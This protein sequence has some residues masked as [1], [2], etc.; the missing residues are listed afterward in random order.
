MQLMGEGPKICTKCWTVIGLDITGGSR[1]ESRKRKWNKLNIPKIVLTN[2][3]GKDTHIT[4]IHTKKKKKKI[5]QEAI[6]QFEDL[7]T[8]LIRL[9]ST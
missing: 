3:E 8:Y 7:N 6:D 1:P 4:R 2:C 9:V 5:N